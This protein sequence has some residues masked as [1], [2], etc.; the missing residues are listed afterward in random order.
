[1]ISTAAELAAALVEDLPPDIR[2]I[3]EAHFLGGESIFTMQ[4]RYK[5]DA[6][7]WRR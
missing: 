3:V 5:F 7:I 1:M 4:R 2:S 6:G